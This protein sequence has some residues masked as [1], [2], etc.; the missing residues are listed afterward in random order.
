MWI[1]GSIFVLA[2]STIAHLVKE[3]PPVP[4]AANK[5]SDPAQAPGALA[6]A[7]A[8]P[9]RSLMGRL[10]GALKRAVAIVTDAVSDI[11]R[12]AWPRVR[13]TLV[14]GVEAIAEAAIAS[15]LPS[16]ASDPTCA[17]PTRALAGPQAVS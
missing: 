13:S 16:D 9:S 2:V 1:I 11:V 17:R 15:L 14:K 5:E 3:E 10:A 8:L 4:K 12:T 6:V 7:V